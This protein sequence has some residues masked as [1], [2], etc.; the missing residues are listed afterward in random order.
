MRN[1]IATVVMALAMAS[2]AQALTFKKGEVLGSD[3]KVYEGASP[4]QLE[5]MVAKAKAGGDRGGVSGNNVFVIVGENVTFIPVEDLKGKTDETMIE[6]VGDAVVQDLTGN[7]DIKFSQV[8]AV[9][10]IAE[11][12]GLSVEEVLNNGDIAGIDPELMAEIEK[13][14]S[15]TGIGV[16]N[17]MAVNEVM[18]S[19]PEDQMNEFMEDLGEMIEEGMAAEID[20]FLTE[21]REIE[22]ALDAIKQFDS[23]ESCV[24]GGGGSVCDD[25]DAL[26][27]EKGL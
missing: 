10:E 6:I 16:D 8:E 22:G 15:E 18:E 24:A 11:N 3:G 14:S 12:T 19:M 26:M 27:E 5:N 7:S 17:L 2:Q 1:V 25:V 4:Q 13:V 9:S 21:L 20:E 23:Y